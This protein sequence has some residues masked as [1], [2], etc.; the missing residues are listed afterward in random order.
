MKSGLIVAYS[1]LAVEYNDQSVL[2]N[3]HCATGFR[4]LSRPRCNI[5]QHLSI[6]DYKTVRKIII[7]CVL[8][9]D[10]AKVCKGEL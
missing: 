7:T 10:M 3:H 6:D 9:T 8:S 5:F 1:D 2:E 4:I